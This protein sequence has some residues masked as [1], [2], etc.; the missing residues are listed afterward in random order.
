MLK[1]A[2]DF[3]A[4][5]RALVIKLR[6]H[7]D[8]L[9]TAPVFSALRQHAPRLELDAL[10][11]R[12]TE[13]MLSGHPA[14]SRIF[15]VDR[16]GKK[17]GALARIAAEWRLLKELRARN[18]DLIVHLT[19]SPRGAWLARLLG[20]RYAVAR[21]YPG[22]RGR[23]WRT[24]FTHVY[25]ISGKPRHTVEIHLDALR[26]LGLQPQGER[27][28]TLVPGAEAEAAVGELL[29]RHGLAPK[30]YVHLHPTSRWLFKCWEVEKY[31]ALI[32]ALQDTGVRVVVTASPAEHELEFVRRVMAKNRK[33]AVDLSG[34]LSLKQL[35]ALT[36]QAKCFVGVDSVPMH[37]A[38]AMQTPVAALFGPSGDLEWGPWQV[39]A[40][41]LTTNHSCRPCGMDGCA[42]SKI[43]ECLTTIT[44]E[45][46]LGA[47]KELL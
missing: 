2:I 39:R 28:L 38:A 25:R 20:A 10:I 46:V 17:N 13:E 14:I 6:H 27:R 1:D 36:A 21:E 45:E 15:T 9:L 31:A 19:E 24:S 29:R 43:S 23:L 3:S 32:E 35:A 30:S 16:A 22:K 42:G 34:K 33:P 12:D 4:I 8:V 26:R 47:I 5:R 41:V 40:R 44:V 11:Y 37:I 18:Y 7:G